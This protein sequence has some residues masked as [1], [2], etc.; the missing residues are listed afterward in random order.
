MLWNRI[1]LGAV[2]GL[3]GLLP[4]VFLVG[5]TYALTLAPSLLNILSPVM[6][7]LSFLSAGIVSGYVVGQRKRKRS[8]A[9]AIIGATAGFAAG[10]IYSGALEGFFIYRYLT[11]PAIMRD[12][13][14]TSHPLRVTFVII[15]LSFFIVALAM[16]TT[17]FTARQLP[18][19]R[20][21]RRLTG[22]YRAIPPTPDA[23]NQSQ[24]RTPRPH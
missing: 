4:L 24:L 21:S 11:T 19:P 23:S 22:Q 15:L 9:K 18:P 14:F 10:I 20:R 17:Q 12:A 8:E 2:S 3:L 16:A 1:R 6:I 5:I 7:V 13:V